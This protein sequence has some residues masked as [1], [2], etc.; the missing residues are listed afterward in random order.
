[1]PIINSSRKKFLGFH[2]QSRRT[3]GQET[4]ANSLKSSAKKCL[5]LGTIK[6][7]WHLRSTIASQVLFLIVYNSFLHRRLQL[8]YVY[9]METPTVF[10]EHPSWL[11][12]KCKLLSCRSKNRYPRALSPMKDYGLP[13]LMLCPWIISTL[14]W[15]ITL[16]NSKGIEN[17]QSE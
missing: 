13:R 10:Q 12:G 11:P 6:K 5:I 16:G 17:H 15:T 9:P 8:L 2:Y 1:M 3:D 14:S 4:K 7:R